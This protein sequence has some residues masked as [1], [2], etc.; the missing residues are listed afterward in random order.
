[1]AVDSTAPTQTVA[2]L[3]MGGGLIEIAA[4]TALIGSTTA[5]SL[6]LGNKGAPG[7]L[8]GTMSIFGALSVIKACIAAA[9]PDWLRETI[10]VRS[11]ETDAAIGVS[12][13][14]NVKGHKI[15]RRAASACG[16]ACK[17]A[18]NSSDKA[19]SESDSAEIS[20]HDTY[21]FDQS[22]SGLLDLIPESGPHDALQSYVLVQDTYVREHIRI[23]RWKD[24]VAIFASMLKLAEVFVLWRYEATILT[25]ISGC[26]WVF[27][28]A[29]SI[30][31]QLLGVSREYHK[32][33]TR[34]DVDMV[35]GQLPTP[36]RAG[37]QRR[38]LLGAPQNVRHSVYWK[39][40]WGIGSI[41]CTASVIVT[42][43][44]LG[45]QET[46]IFAIW[47]GFQ[48]SWLALRSVYYHFSEAT[49]KIFHHPI[50]LKNDWKT[51][52]V[53]FKMRV[54]RLISAISKY[55]MLIHPRGPYCYE[56][57]LSSYDNAH[58]VQY[59]FILTPEDLNEGKVKLS[60][61]SVIGDTL[62]SSTAWLFGSKLSGMDLYDSCIVLLDLDGTTVAIPSARVMSGKRTLHVS[63]EETG[64]GPL[65]PPRGGSNTGKDL[66]WW[67][68]IPCR[69]GLWLQAHSE[70]MKFLG[71]RTASIVSDEQLTK[72]LMSGELF[73]GIS[74]VGHVYE[75]IRN[76]V[77]G[78][79][80]LQNLLR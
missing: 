67:Y 76:S 15:Q 6:V 55:Q 26:S 59:R 36:I 43:I 24:W 57:D 49:E 63:D 9:T 29:A 34:W 60:V 19:V 72:K 30:L 21:A 66:S 5:E 39:I 42:Y 37:G 1:M 45:S 68:W 73:V 20:R 70:D 3:N 65:F 22:S 40:S 35:A 18:I 13:D 23:I 46:T 56:E 52:S 31:L 4:L 14:L 38:L 62:L 50:L 41:V 79:E 77:A 25:L 7:L 53:Q 2:S 74:E 32:G 75:I 11:K 54:Q 80:G 44:I 47:T 8:W 51:L 48:F 61:T 16:I 64:I 12:L 10:G 71:K 28:F 78:F 17:V 27:F 33:K 69:A 58:N